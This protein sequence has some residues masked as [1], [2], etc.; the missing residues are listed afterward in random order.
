MPTVVLILPSMTYRA[1]DFLEAAATLHADVVVATEGSQAMAGSMGERY[2]P[3][4]LAR[5][6]YSAGRIAEQAPAA[7]AVIAVDDA[8]VEIAAL[9]A[10]TLGLPFNPQHAVAATRDKALLRTTLTAAGVRQP[11]FV[12]VGPDDDVAGAAAEV[13]FPAVVKPVALSASRGV[14]R[15]DDPHDA[16][17]GGQRVRAIVAAAG[18]DCDPR[19]VVE[20]YLPGDE[21]AIE[22]LLGGGELEVLAIFDKP[23]PLTGPYF[24]ETLLVSPARVS[25]EQ[26]DAIVAAAGEAT[27]ALGLVTGPVHVEVRVHDGAVTVIEAA[28]RSI[29]GLCGRALRFGALAVSLE[30][31]LLRHALGY[32]TKATD[33]Q[34]PATGVLMLPI[35]RSG[36]Y[37]DVEGVD[38]ALRVPGVDRLTITLTPGEI[39]TPLPEGDRYLGFLFARGAT[40]DD[41]EA[42]LRAAHE[43]LD[44]VIE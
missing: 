30:V 10:Q 12:V 8:G 26:R 9:T 37:R 11:R 39:A 6:E 32:P 33:A 3:I 24:E 15:V 21:Y 34:V 43:L 35:P 13:G 41:V 44:V 27:A 28:A 5:T 38:E 16:L 36:E 25:D 14:I 29:G 1:P 42:S 23:D 19:L 31:V 7:D 20:E 40:A 4:D 22:G 18:P 2:V 17:A